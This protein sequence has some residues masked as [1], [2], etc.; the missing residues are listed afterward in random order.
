MTDQPEEPT[1]ENEDKKTTEEE[2][3]WWEDLQRQVQ[4]VMGNMGTMPGMGPMGFTTDQSQKTPD[5]TPSSPP[6]PEETPLD[7]VRRF[8]LKPREIKDHLD[9]FVIRQDDAKEVLSVAIC[10]HYNQARQTLESPDAPDSDYVKPNVLLLGPTGVGKTYLIRHVAKLVGVPFVK[11]DATKFSETG[12]VGYDVDD[13]VRDLVK[14]ADGNVDLAAFGII[15]IDEIDKIAGQSSQGG[16]R[17]VSGR[18]VQTNL[19]KLMEETEVNLT[20]QTDMLGQ[21]QAMMEMQ[22]GGTPPPQRIS[23]RNILFIASGAFMPMTDIV[24][25]RLGKGSIGFDP[26]APQSADDTQLLKQADT[27]DFITYGLEPEF[28]GRLPV[29]VACEPLNANDL[30]KILSDAEGN[31]LNQ[32]QSEFKGYGINAKFTADAVR[33]IAELAESQGTGARGLTTVLERRLR[34]FKFALPSTTVSELE[35]DAQTLREPDAAL[36][37]LLAEQKQ[38]QFQRE[39]EDLARFATTFEAENGMPLEFTAAAATHLVERATDEQKT[40]HGICS[41]LFKDYPY[42]VRLLKERG[43]IGPLQL[44]VEDLANPDSYL[45]DRVVAAYQDQ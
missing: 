44:D 29:R 16:G 31:I 18:G 12:Y 4:E 24:R 23:T 42:C 1:N 22:R 9:R 36:T 11:A 26:A 32:V 21:M 15:Y 10:D 25:R 7:R 8:T 5:E 2:K 38:A 37:A 40:V 30:E 27:R 45:S 35:L 17:D 6:V 34:P 14:A 33:E 13:M 3:E 20:S 28:I 19:L 39:H 43:V 41:R